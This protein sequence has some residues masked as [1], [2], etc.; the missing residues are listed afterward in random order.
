MKRHSLRNKVFIKQL[1][2]YMLILFI[3][4]VFLDLFFMSRYMKTYREEVYANLQSDLNAVSGRLEEFMGT[5]GRIVT[6]ISLQHNLNKFR[7]EDDPLAA[8]EIS[9]TLAVCRITNSSIQD[10]Y[11]YLY[12]DSYAIGSYGTC[13]LDVFLSEG[14]K[15]SGM[16]PQSLGV[17][18]DTLEM[19]YV[20][21][22]QFVETVR[23]DKN[24]TVMVYP[25][26]TDYQTIRGQVI[27]LI[28]TQ[29]IL[30]LLE[31]TLR[32][33]SSSIY[34]YSHNDELL[35]QSNPLQDGKFNPLQYTEQEKGGM[36]SPVKIDGKSYLF[37]QE[38]TGGLRWKLYTF[39]PMGEEPFNKIARISFEMVLLTLLILVL[40]AFV[41]FGALRVNYRPIKYL[42]DKAERAEIPT[43]PKHTN[44][45]EIISDT[46]DYLSERNTR[47]ASQIEK[48]LSS[49]RNI[50]LQGLLTGSYTSLEDFNHD[51][52]EVDLKFSAGSFAVSV[53]LLPAQEDTA[54]ML[55]N[56]IAGHFEGIPET[57]CVYTI[58]P[59]QLI[60][61]H[62]LRDHSTEIIE[63][64]LNEIISGSGG[65]ITA[66]LGSVVDDVSMIPRS[67]L[68]ASAALDYR[69]VK[70]NGALILF[71]EAYLSSSG[72]A[73][74]PADHFEKLKNYI[75][76]SDENGIM[77]ETERIINFID[78][79]K[80]PLF[81]AKGICFDIIRLFLEYNKEKDIAGKAQQDIQILTGI[82]TVHDMAGFIRNLSHNL[83]GFEGRDQAD[84][85]SLIK[86]VVAYI[87]ANYTRCDFSIQEISNEFNML[88]PNLSQ[89]FKTV[90]GRNILDYSTSLRMEKAKTLLV[91]TDI[92]LKDLSYQVG[93]YNVSSFIRRFKQTQGIT[94]GDY[95]NIY[96]AAR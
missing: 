9:S 44:E 12:D 41:I 3:P 91:E 95:R 15:L 48:N 24:F 21:G 85:I 51:S 36:P 34:I 86:K 77:E 81:A 68:E 47:L 45:L 33:Y 22:D 17:F 62:G 8:R 4:L 67:Y 88:L 10:I 43:D 59:R 80:L 14:L 89:L 49:L 5:T 87:N 64:K 66:G 60:L 1:L 94:P 7:F 30:G 37:A 82:D 73:A 40:A 23:I 32:K 65:L 56:S 52:P 92:P 61:I 11:L 79:N 55:M 75:A 13:R 78:K 29:E 69:F 58:D 28:D 26:L 46:L 84:A 72:A 20:F 31:S 90:T 74:Y 42:R 35:V 96:S 76:G 2:S 39:A 16:T 38:N 71:H 53:L 50:K 6:Q 57:E 18:L 54:H 25:L 93:Y 19:P 70:G 63:G 27:F 83:S